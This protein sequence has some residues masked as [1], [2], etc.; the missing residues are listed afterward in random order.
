MTAAAHAAA[1]RAAVESA[2][3]DGALAQLAPDVVFRSPVVHAPYT[4]LE[5]VRPILA[6]VMAVFEDFRYVA[7]YAGPDG[8]VLEFACRVDRFDL[9]GI[10]VLRGPGPF[11]ELAVLV[12][13]Y[14][15]A[16]ALRSRMAALLTGHDPA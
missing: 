3:L 11:T 1:F 15:A 4:G 14:S 13:P 9:Q 7:E 8:H 10:D 12:R 6:G 2:D 5:A 16:T